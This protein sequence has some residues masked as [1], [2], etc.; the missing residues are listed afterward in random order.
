MVLFKE[1][2]EAMVVAIMDDG[3]GLLAFGEGTG[4][5]ESTSTSSS[6]ES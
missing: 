4:E 2:V 6:S 1:S 5:S 3:T